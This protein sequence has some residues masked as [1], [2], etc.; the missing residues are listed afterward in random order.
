[1]TAPP[2]VHRHKAPRRDVQTAV[3]DLGKRLGVTGLVLAA[4]AIGGVIKA[5]ELDVE[6]RERP[7]IH[8]GAIGQI[9]SA[10]TFDVTVLGVRGST[11]LK[12][13][14]DVYDTDGVWVLVK[15]RLMANRD[16]SFVGYAAVRDTAGRTYRASRRMDQPLDSRELQP[17]LPVEGEVA[18]EVPRTA[19]AGL[20]VRFSSGSYDLRMDAMPEI[21]LGIDRVAAARWL[22]APD[23]LTL[24][25][26]EAGP[27]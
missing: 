4:V 13:G 9:R 2:P 12:A 21:S 27:T 6:Q 5:H 1:M 14:D 25:D 17:G 10:R 7:F 16:P 20:A 15:V 22:A 19:V 11:K 3:A 18:F 23:A 26:A 8:A 24:A